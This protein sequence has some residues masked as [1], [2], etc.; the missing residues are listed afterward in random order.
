MRKLSMKINKTLINGKHQQR[1]F[2]VN[3]IVW[4]QEKCLLTRNMFMFWK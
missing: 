4:L 2:Y 1:L 3:N